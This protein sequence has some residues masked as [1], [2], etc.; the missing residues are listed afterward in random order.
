M[1]D[2]FVITG[3]TA[4]IRFHGVEAWY[5]HDYYEPY[6]LGSIILQGEEKPDGSGEY[7]IID[8]QQRLVSLAI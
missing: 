8:G 1:P 5:R 6:F 2:D 4:Y 3:Y 7:A